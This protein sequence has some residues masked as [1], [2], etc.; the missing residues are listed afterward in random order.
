[1]TPGSDAGLA[2][3][4]G[5]FFVFRLGVLMTTVL[6]DMIGFLIVLPLL[7]FY[8]LRFGASDTMVGLLISTFA[9]AQLASSP[10]WGRLSDRL[11]R[12]PVILGSLLV[13]AAAFLLF[14]LAESVALLFASRLVQGIG[15]GTTGV[16]QAYVSDTAAPHQRTK[17]LGWLSAATSAGVMIGPLIGSAAARL[18]EAAPGYIAAGLCVVNFLFAWWLLPESIAREEE[19]AAPST[20]GPME[21]IPPPARLR[22]S[23][24]RSVVDVLSHPANDRSRLI[25]IYT[26]GMMAFMAMNGVV[27]LYL[28]RRFGVSA[29]NVGWFYFYVG[30]LSLLMRALLLGPINE[31]LGDVRTLRIGALALGLGLALAPVPS[32][33]WGLAVVIALVPIGTALL[34]PATTSLVSRYS[35][36]GET[37]QNLGV[38]QAFGGVAR[39]LGPV[40]ATAVFGHIGRAAPFWIAAALMG[41]VL[42]IALSVSRP[43]PSSPPAPLEPA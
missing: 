30:G 24:R 9:F 37:G 15:G 8:A 23:L 40:W 4:S 12:R 10:L 41:G 43:R 5:R 34:F 28:D 27:V 32:T 22:P 39:M 20:G 33:L 42:A 16:L 35:L 36:R 14:G 18:G 1:M 31:R 21:E 25:W 3:M 29:E 19:G 7:P 11:G 13:S 26:F 38:Q 2:P 6:V 17:A